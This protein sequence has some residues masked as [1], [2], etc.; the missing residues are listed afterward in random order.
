MKA[1]LDLAPV[2]G[3]KVL[4]R[5]DF[6]VP[7]TD[8]GAVRDDARIRAALPTIKE[9]IKRE[10]AVVLVTHLG[11]P[12]GR[13]VPALT[14]APLASRLS[15]LLER[16]VEV[17]RRGDRLIDVFGAQHRAPH[18]QSGFIAFLVHRFPLGVSRF[19]QRY[20]ASEFELNIGE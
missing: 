4:V 16:P 8:G 13:V 9:L 1:G 11:R 7:L 14:T 17:V 19:L 10:A 18:Q 2:D 12:R 3:A 5:V 15:E 6:N 20:S